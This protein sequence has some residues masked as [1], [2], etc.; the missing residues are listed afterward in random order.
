M[1]SS[2]L[3]YTERKDPVGTSCF[4]AAR[5]E[6]SDPLTVK[7]RRI[8]EDNPAREDDGQRQSPALPAVGPG[9]FEYPFGELTA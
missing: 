1:S 4:F 5:S 2:R 6:S 3:W 7:R 9:E 8:E